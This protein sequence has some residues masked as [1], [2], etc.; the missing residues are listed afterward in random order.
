[1]HTVLKATLSDG[2][3]HYATSI[4]LVPK[5]LDRLVST[6]LNW[7]DQLPIQPL[8]KTACDRKLLSFFKRQW[9]EGSHARSLHCVGELMDLTLSRGVF[10]SAPLLQSLPTPNWE[11]IE[12]LGPQCGDMAIPKAIKRFARQSEGSIL[13][14]SVAAYETGQSCLEYV[15]PGWLDY[16][17]L[18]FFHHDTR[19]VKDFIVRLESTALDAM[20]YRAMNE[21]TAA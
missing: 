7:L 8:K 15:V 21:R 13:T 14:D 20:V 11:T 19:I 17:D 12:A 2:S 5:P 9:D 4:F 1:M 16:L 3:E 6:S 10:A 18:K